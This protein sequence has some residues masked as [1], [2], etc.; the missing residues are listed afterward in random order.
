VQ[1]LSQLGFRLWPHVEPFFK[2][3]KRVGLALFFLCLLGMALTFFVGCITPRTHALFN[4]DY[5]DQAPRVLMDIECH[6]VRHFV[7]GVAAC[8]EK[9]P[10][11]ANIKVKGM[12]IPGRIVYSDGIKKHV[13]DFNYTTK[14]WWIFKKK[15]IDTTWL[16]LNLGELNSLYGDIPIAIDVQGKSDVGIINARGVIYHRVCNDKD[17]PCSRLVVDFD[18]SGNIKNTYEGQLGS[19]A[20]LS[21]SSQKFKLNL[22]TPIYTLVKGAKLIVRSGRSGWKHEHEVTAGD[23]EVGEHKFFYPAVMTGPDLIQIT[24]FQWEQGIL[25]E[26]HTIIMLVGYSPN[27]T[28]IDKPHF[29]NGEGEFCLPFTAD[30]LEINEPGRISSTGK[31]CES[32]K[33]SW[34]ACAYA[35]DRESGDVSHSCMKKGQEVNL[36]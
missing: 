32:I 12:P 34:D 3:Y 20:R 14:G 5:S 28:G 18:C 23:A 26:Y 36:L 2:R 27:W 11:Q 25:Q 17:I 10:R 7:E 8:E 6:G 4:L 15:K 22:K 31:G 24:V 21:G 30:L 1:F 35:F 13:D 19:C 16:P 9:T 29:I 33:S